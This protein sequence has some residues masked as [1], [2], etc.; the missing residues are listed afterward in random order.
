MNTR[1]N[2][3]TNIGFC[4]P[5][6]RISILRPISFNKILPINIIKILVIFKNSWYNNYAK[7]INNIFRI[8]YTQGIAMPFLHQ[9]NEFSKS[10][11][12]LK[13]MYRINS[14]YVIIKI[15]F[16]T[17]ELRFS[18]RGFTVAHLF[19]VKTNVLYQINI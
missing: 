19:C 6:C 18:V 16:A 8:Y 17:L 2:D 10:A 11:I 3:R 13:L 15:C 4:S 7:Q 9:L 12:P 5:F 1:F 14:C